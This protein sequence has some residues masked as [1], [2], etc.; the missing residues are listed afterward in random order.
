MK[1]FVLLCLFS[2]GITF[3]KEISIEKY[4]GVF[5]TSIPDAYQFYPTF[6][7][8]ENVIMT[9]KD[10]VLGT[11]SLSVTI[12]GIKDAKLNS[13][14]LS[15]TQIDYQN[16]RNKY[17]DKRGLKLIEFIPYSLKKNSQGYQIH[18]IGVIYSNAN[19]IT[20]EMSYMIECPESFVHAK[21]LGDVGLVQDLTSIKKNNFSNETHKEMEKSALGITCSKNKK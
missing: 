13:A 9:P 2:S 1:F 4:K 18:T 8:L 17:L 5:K 6:M 14:E 15:S 19:R 21:F 20:L 11:S 3:G 7:G 10:S 16:G 12:T